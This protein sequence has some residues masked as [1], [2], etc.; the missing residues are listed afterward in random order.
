MEE[1]EGNGDGLVSVAVTSTIEVDD[2]ANGGKWV[3]ISVTMAIIDEEEAS[4]QESVP[5]TQLS[6]EEDPSEEEVKD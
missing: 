1:A 4:Q 5:V 2:D 6:E 3:P